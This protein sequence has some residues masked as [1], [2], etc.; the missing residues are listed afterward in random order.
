MHPTESG[1]FTFRLKPTWTSEHF[2]R[3]KI[4]FNRDLR[5]INGAV[6]LVFYVLCP[7]YPSDRYVRPIQWRPSCRMPLCTV[8]T[9]RIKRFALESGAVLTDIV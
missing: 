3:I 2:Q 8:V 6:T 7:V 4:N 9:I 5:K 1:S